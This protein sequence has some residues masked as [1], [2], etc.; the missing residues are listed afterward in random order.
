MPRITIGQIRL[1]VEAISKKC[2][3]LQKKVTALLVLNILSLSAVVY[4]LTA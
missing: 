2:E 4:L 1:E 3:A